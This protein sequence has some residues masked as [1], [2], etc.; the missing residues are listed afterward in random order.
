VLCVIGSLYEYAGK[1]SVYVRAAVPHLP[2]EGQGT[3]RRPSLGNLTSLTFRE[4][5]FS[6]TQWSRGDTKKAGA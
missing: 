6:E 3:P 4:R 2:F 5:E 1:C